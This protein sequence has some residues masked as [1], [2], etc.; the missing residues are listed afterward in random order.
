[1]AQNRKALLFVSRENI[2]KIK[3]Y[4][5]NL[6]RVRRAIKLLLII[7]KYTV[8]NSNILC[9]LN[10]HGPHFAKLFRRRIASFVGVSDGPTWYIDKYN[11]DSPSWITLMSASNNIR[12]DLLYYYMSSNY[13]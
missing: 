1:L 10:A 7:S 8:S 2:D 11:L 3:P 4:M 13:R 6:F 5:L 12:V 9:K